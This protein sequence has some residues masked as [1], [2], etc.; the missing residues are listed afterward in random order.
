[1]VNGKIPDNFFEV[2]E[3]CEDRA[4]NFIATQPDL[5][6]ALVIGFKQPDDKVY[7]FDELVALSPI[8]VILKE[9]STDGKTNG[10]N[11]IINKSSSEDCKLLTLFHEWA[12]LR[13]GNA[14]DY[15]EFEAE[16]AAY[17]VYHSLTS[18][19]KTKT[20]SELNDSERFLCSFP[21]GVLRGRGR[22]AVL[23]AKEILKGVKN[24]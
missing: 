17:I 4:I 24:E 21:S 10:K 13:L 12:H 11:I 19:F 15:D 7:S 5:L 22:K 16:T 6:K 14:E 23:C 2:V 8:P 1:M 20:S 9:Q 3:K 18:P